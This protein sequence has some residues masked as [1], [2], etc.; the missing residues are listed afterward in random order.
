MTLENLYLQKGRKY[1]KEQIQME[2]LC[3]YRVSSSIQGGKF[4]V[5]SDRTTSLFC[6]PRQSNQV[7]VQLVQFGDSNRFK[8]FFLLLFAK[9]F[10]QILESFLLK[11]STMFTKFSHLNA[12]SVMLNA[13]MQQFLKG[14]KKASSQQVK[15]HCDEY[16]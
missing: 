13:I 1:L 15:Y 2:N 4:F 14:F 6:S 8:E 7:I 3:I 16:N 12:T 10:V 5:C 9:K 11:N